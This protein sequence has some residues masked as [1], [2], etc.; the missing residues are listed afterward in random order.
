VEEKKEQR[1]WRNDEWV[2]FAAATLPSVFSARERQGF[3]TN[4]SASE[5]H[6]LLAS[7]VAD[8]AD[9]MWLEM[10]RRD[11]EDYEQEKTPPW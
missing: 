7:A 11:D 9:A 10:R 3:M 4:T 5:A 2:Q 8:V 1:I 6:Q